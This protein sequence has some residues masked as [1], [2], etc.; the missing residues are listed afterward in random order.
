M[1]QMLKL[2]YKSI[3][4]TKLINNKYFSVNILLFYT[5]S[6][7]QREEYISLTLIFYLF[8]WQNVLPKKCFKFYMHTHF[9]VAN[10]PKVH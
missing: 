2:S 4:C 8:C 10:V 7:E 6:F 1:H 5:F 9:P 3:H